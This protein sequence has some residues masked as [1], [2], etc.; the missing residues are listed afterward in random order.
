MFLYKYVQNPNPRQGKILPNTF[1]PLAGPRINPAQSVEET[2]LTTKDSLP[3]TRNQ[4]MI[5]SRALWSELWSPL[6]NYLQFK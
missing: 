5:V 3:Y 2:R 1:V 4:Q 6:M